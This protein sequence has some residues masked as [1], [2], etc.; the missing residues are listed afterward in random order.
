MSIPEALPSQ[1]IAGDTWQWTRSLADYPAG[2]WTATAYF[3][4]RDQTFNVI[5]SASGTT[6]SFTIAAATTG[7][8]R[9]GQYRWRLRVTN[10]SATFTAESGLVDV[11]PDPAA[12]GKRDTRSY[13]RQLLDAVEATILGRATSDQLSMQIATGSASRSISRTPMTELIALR[14]KLKWEVAMEENVERMEAGLSS[15][16]R[17]YVRFGRA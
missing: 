12:A 2:T 4:N 9:A 15:K 6:H 16:K 3:E 10:G 14:D 5:G 17:I 11:L 13:A 8:Y 7:G 1:L